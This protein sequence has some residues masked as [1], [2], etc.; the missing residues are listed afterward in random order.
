MS[1][2][3]SCGHQLG[4]GRFCTNCGAPVDSSLPD[5]TP[6]STPVTPAT[7]APPVSV[8][9]AED[10]WRTDTAERRLPP[11]PAAP[12]A[13]AV[14]A[15]PRTPPA[16]VA[17]PPPPRYPL[18]ADEVAGYTPYGPLTT[19]PAE[20]APVPLLDATEPPVEAE[21]PHY[22]Y[23]YD[24]VGAEIEERHSPVRWILVAALVLVLLA[25]GWWFFVR[26]DGAGSANDPAGAG[27]SAHDDRTG[28]ATKDTDV[29]A[30]A[31]V[32]APR[33]APPN[34]DVNG[35]QV[36]YDASNMLD[37]VPE[38]AWRTAGD[39][40]GMALTFTLRDPTELHQVGL[41][42]GYAKTST[43]AK[44]RSF[45]WYLGNRRV[46]AVV[47]VFDD[48]SKVRQQLKDDKSVQLVD[49]PDVLTSK[50]VLRL[51]TVS[52]PGSGTAARDFTA[53]SEVSLLGTPQG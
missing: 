4:V 25:A 47:W 17:P 15:D 5:A 41:I 6:V 22:D 50:V 51:V 32:K 28:T 49:V 53:I 1:S 45:D 31:A 35:D 20:P 26:D 52:E 48:G 29:A 8:P 9:L 24:E 2:C 19:L 40:S 14:S 16:A 10:D 38:T 46:E 30:R 36:S 23:G 3:T 11:V 34:E 37:G 21:L 33:T 43:D 44:G 7:P 12:A 42:N 13:V 39:A 27:P 18:F